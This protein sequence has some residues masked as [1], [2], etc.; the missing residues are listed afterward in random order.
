MATV[1]TT[2]VETC[3]AEVMTFLIGFLQELFADRAPGDY[4]W[5][6]TE[7]SDIAIHA[8]EADSPD[9]DVSLPRIVVSRGPLTISAIGDGATGNAPLGSGRH[10]LSMIQRMQ[11]FFAVVAG[12]GLEAEKL[13]NW[14]LLMI[15]AFKP[16]LQ[17]HKYVHQ[18]SVQS[19]T[20]GVESGAGAKTG[21]VESPVEKTVV[22]SM[23][24]SIQLTALVDKRAQ[25]GRARRYL[26]ITRA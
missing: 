24:V 14:L 7:D 19:A 3:A 5:D 21:P 2:L 15:Y 10:M 9:A 22:L 25:F 20:I 4:H 6:A 1:P 12:E 26:T 8:A 23:P 17:K 13:A 18:I 16:E 11:I